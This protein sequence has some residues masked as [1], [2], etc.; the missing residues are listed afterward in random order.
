ML[1]HSQDERYSVVEHRLPKHV[2]VCVHA[3]TDQHSAAVVRA[4]LFWLQLSV[5]AALLGLQLSEMDVFP[6][7]IDV[8]IQEVLRLCE[9]AATCTSVVTAAVRDGHSH[10]HRSSFAPSD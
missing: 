1:P 9:E 5:A 4:L 2:D 10:S 8:S 7:Y 6:K 3:G